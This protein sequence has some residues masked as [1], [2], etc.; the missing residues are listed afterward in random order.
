MKRTPSP[1]L[2]LLTASRAPVALILRRGPSKWVE[3]IRWDIR[4]DAFDRGQWFYG[5]IHEE[6][7]DLSPNGELLVYLAARYGESGSPKVT[8]E[9]MRM[10]RR[11]PSMCIGAGSSAA[12]GSYGRSWSTNISA[13]GD[14]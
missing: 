8:Y 1:R 7:S 13:Q 6:R 4:R 12:V 9:S 3:A 5:R 2:S 14:T 10:Q 11:T